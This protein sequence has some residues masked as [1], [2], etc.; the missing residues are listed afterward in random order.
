M[1]TN[2]SKRH[3]DAGRRSDIRLQSQAWFLCVVI[4]AWQCGTSVR[5]DQTR[6]VTTCYLRLSHIFDTGT[7]AEIVE[8]KNGIS[9]YMTQI[10]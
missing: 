2:Q 5:L 9:L 6:N 3:F 10:Q 1:V 4:M 7:G 8:N